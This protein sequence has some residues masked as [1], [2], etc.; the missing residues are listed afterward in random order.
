MQYRH[1]AEWWRD[2]ISFPLKVFQREEERRE[3]DR[4]IEDRGRG[5]F[6]GRLL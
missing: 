1:M 3:E 4:H 6:R 5:G 2:H